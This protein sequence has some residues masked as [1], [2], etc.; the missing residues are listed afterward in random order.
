M[1]TAIR[2][3]VV[4][5]AESIVARYPQ[6]TIGEALRYSDIDG[7][8]D[9]DAL[10][11]AFNIARPGRRPKSSNGFRTESKFTTAMLKELKKIPR[12]YWYRHN[13]GRRGN[14][15]FGDRGSPDI[16]G[17]LP[18]GR[19]A[20]VELKQPGQRLTRDQEEWHA[21]AIGLGALIIVT[22]TMA[23]GIRRVVEGMR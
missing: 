1:I 16:V 9:W 14:V 10:R 21:R 23:D 8:I 18:G 3:A 13:T 4:V 5:A 11:T 20:G 6:I 19:Y 2:S 15:T 17:I 7:N 22:E 12:T